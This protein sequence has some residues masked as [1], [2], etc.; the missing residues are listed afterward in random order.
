MKRAICLII[1]MM[2]LMSSLA[3]GEGL[4]PSM[5]E[6]YGVAMPS[7]GAVLHRYPDSETKQADGSTIQQWRNVTEDDFNAFSEYLAVAGAALEDYAVDHGVLTATI[8][9][10]GKTFLFVY[11][12]NSEAVT[13][14]YPKGT[15][16]ERSYEAESHYNQAIEYM[17]AGQY[18][19]AYLEFCAI[20]DKQYYHDVG[21]LLKSDQNLTAARE[22]TLAPFRNVGGYITFGNYEQ[23]DNT[24]NGKE[25]IEWLV[26][27]YDAK[28]NRVLLISKHGLDSKPYNT[29][30][31]DVTWEMCS[32][33]KWLN[34]DF[35]NKAFSSTEQTAI[36]TTE[37]DNSSGQGFDFTT[38]YGWALK[39][40]GGNNTQDRIFLLSYAEAKKYFNIRKS[41]YWGEEN[42]KSMV[43][44]TAYAKKVGAKTR[45]Q[46]MKFGEWTGQWWLRSPGENQNSAASVN[47]DGTLISLDVNYDDIC[48][49]PAL[50]INLDSGIF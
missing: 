21:S 43:A 16:D 38:V 39:T 9:K 13:V 35:L 30:R 49:R 47:T 15:Y 3:C 12:M 17:A 14:T 25:P 44:P 18:G 28:N 20:E 10:K 29:E 19:D 26:L 24:G 33:R 37:V 40:D 50:W 5:T 1:T 36:L 41:L 45:L 34:N 42:E 7:L 48:V 46:W 4:L 8:G 6:A 27:D 22:A 2:L 11:V 31:V 23:D 32:L